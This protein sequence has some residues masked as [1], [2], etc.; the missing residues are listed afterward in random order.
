[1][2]SDLKEEDI[3]QVILISDKMVGESFQTPDSIKK[4]ITDKHKI[5]KVYKFNGEII[6]FVKGKIIGKSTF[7]DTLLKTNSVIKT[8]LMGEGN[9]GLAETIC[10]KNKFRGTGIAQELADDLIGS[11]K[12]VEPIDIICSTLWKAGGVANARR[13][14]ENIG[15]KM[16][17]EIEDYWYK[18]SIVKDYICPSCGKPPCKCSMIFYRLEIPLNGIPGMCESDYPPLWE[19]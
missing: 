17:T 12:Q 15:F 18:D 16:I 11:L 7:K 10:V 19:R 14:V 13:I 5:L 4:Y 1:M 8:V 9:M 3:E 6:G 2:I